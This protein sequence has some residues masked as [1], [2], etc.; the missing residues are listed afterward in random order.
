MQIQP[1]EEQ[2]PHQRP[3]RPCNDHLVRTAADTWDGMNSRGC[4]VA[5]FPARSSASPMSEFRCALATGAKLTNQPDGACRRPCGRRRLL[6]CARDCL[7]MR[8]LAGDQQRYPHATPGFESDV[9]G[10]CIARHCRGRKGHVVHA[11]R[12]PA[13]PVGA[14]F[15]E[16]LHDRRLHPRPAG[17]R[18][19]LVCRGA[20]E[21]PSRRLTSWRRSISIDGSPSTDW[22]RARIR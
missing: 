3:T 9:D 2:R 20:I 14:W 12:D 10:P 4:G 19:R 13:G 21:W 5:G 22:K 1:I 6:D 18:N 7:T 8:R 11:C 15:G 16:R 17:R